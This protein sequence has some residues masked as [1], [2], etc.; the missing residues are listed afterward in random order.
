MMSEWVKECRKCK[1]VCA[2]CSSRIGQRC[3]GCDRYDEFEPA[4]HIEYCP[5]NGKKLEMLPKERIIM[6]NL[7]R[8][9]VD[10]GSGG[11]GFTDTFDQL[12]EDVNDDFGEDA[13]EKIKE[14]ALNS[15]EGDEYKKYGA[16]ILNIGIEC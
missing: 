12:I 16:Y 15:K 4:E 8:Y 2:C 14:W 13:V 1:Y 11:Y 3:S 9:E 6:E 5:L 10:F 7:F